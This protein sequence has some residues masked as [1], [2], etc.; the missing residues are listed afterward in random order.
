MAGNVSEWTSTIGQDPRFKDRSVAII[1]GGN[2]MLKQFDI[3]TRLNDREP[4]LSQRAQE[5]VIGFRVA[6]DHPPS[7]DWAERKS[8]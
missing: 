6:W 5:L 8:P 4:R 2:F 7:G 3:T 1:R